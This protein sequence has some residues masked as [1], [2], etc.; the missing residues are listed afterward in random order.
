MLDT[1]PPEIFG[2]VLEIAVEIW[3]IGFLPPVRLVS[4]TCNDVV[5]STPSLWGI[6]TLARPFSLTV[7]EK[8]LER[9]KQS[10][11]RLSYPRKGFPREKRFVRLFNQL[12]TLTDNWIRA[13]LS[14]EL[15]AKT[16][17]SRLRRLTALDVRGSL[18]LLPESFFDNRLPALHS[19]ALSHVR[20]MDGWRTGFFSPHITDFTLGFCA[21]RSTTLIRQALSL[22]PNLYSLHFENLAFY[23]V[24]DA[25]SPIK[26]AA[27]HHLEVINCRHATGLL[28]ELCAPNL[29]VLSIRGASTNIEMAL[30]LADWSGRVQELLRLRCP[31][32]VSVV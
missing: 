3:G 29:R 8:Q 9:A 26:L 22:L 17:A 18:E 7:L 5:D 30:I 2:R 13:E 16:Q 12:L 20:E 10:D 15:L 11:I 21:P 32:H 24:F 1:L 27:L 31:L 19:L 23:H 14:T 28:L 25:Q 4:R 6:I